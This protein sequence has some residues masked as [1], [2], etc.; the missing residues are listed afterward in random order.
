MMSPDRI[1]ENRGAAAT[2]LELSEAEAQSCEKAADVGAPAVL[3]AVN[4]HMQ[5]R[6]WRSCPQPAIR[7]EDI[8]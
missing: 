1:F 8:E 3:L 5:L 6:Q 4:Q 2:L 7:L